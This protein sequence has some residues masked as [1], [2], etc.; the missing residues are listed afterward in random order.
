[1][2]YNLSSRSKFGDLILSTFYD[3]GEI[4]QF[5][6]TYD[7]IMSTPNE[8]SLEGWG[9]SLDLVTL[10]RLNVKVIWADSIGENPG[11]TVSGMDSDGL[12]KS[13]RVW[14]LARISF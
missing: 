10:E 13:S 3:Y 8:Y 7:I 6:E 2:Q 1:M 14:A 11:K 4:K 9:V 5:K 12:N